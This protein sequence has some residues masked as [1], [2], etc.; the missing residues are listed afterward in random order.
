MEEQNPYAPPQSSPIPEPGLTPEGTLDLA[1]RGSRFAGALIDGIIGIVIVI[2]AGIGIWATGLFSHIN[3]PL[4]LAEDI[5]FMLVVSIA[6]MAVFILINYQP[7]ATRGQSIGKM[8]VGIKIVRSD[9]SPASIGRIIGHRY[10]AL[11]MMGLVP[12]VGSIL[13]LIDSLLIFRQE[14][15]CLHDDIADTR[16]VRVPPKPLH[17]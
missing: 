4:L 13:P 11:S 7:W 1:D 14:R 15:N 16:V 9:G 10:L 6:G 3:D 8:A 5:L 17:S 12:F 2:L